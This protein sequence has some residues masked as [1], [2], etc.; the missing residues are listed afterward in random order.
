MQQVHAFVVEQVIN[1]WVIVPRDLNTIVVL[2]RVCSFWKEVVDREDVWKNFCEYLGWVF[3]LVLPH[4]S[5]P[6]GRK[7][8]ERREDFYTTRSALAI[9]IGRV[10]TTY[11]P[12][13]RRVFY[14]LFKH[15]YINNAP[16]LSVNLH[17]SKR[18]N[19]YMFPYCSFS[20]GLGCFVKP[21]LTPASLGHNEPFKLVKSV[22]IRSPYFDL[23]YTGTG[24]AANSSGSIIPESIDWDG[25]SGVVCACG[26]SNWL[27]VYHHHHDHSHES[28]DAAEFRCSVCSIYLM[29][30]S[31][32]VV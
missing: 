5:A 32:M 21:L 31:Q 14:S 19:Y 7:W 9:S 24:I 3:P 17:K 12:D 25:V 26:A 13:S 28:G 15:C 11:V 22:V 4:V 30:D 6:E 20:L 8:K 23:T 2:R 27:A 1:K 18:F 29:L 10:N 16:V